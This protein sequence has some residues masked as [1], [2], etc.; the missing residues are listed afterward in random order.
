MGIYNYELLRKKYLNYSKFKKKMND[1]EVLINLYQRLGYKFVP[2]VLNGMFAYVVYDKLKDKLI[3]VNDI[4]G[5]KIYTFI[6]MKN[7]L[8]FL[9]Q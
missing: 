2:Q 3:I 9:Q 4:Q 5:E 7:I 8:L 6:R 1:T